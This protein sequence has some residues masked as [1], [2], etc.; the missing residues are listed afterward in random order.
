MAA[1]WK[2]RKLMILLVVLAVFSVTAVGFSHPVGVH[3]RAMSVLLRFADPDAKG[4]G[5]R[6]AQHP[7]TSEVGTTQVGTESFRYRI[8]KPSDVNNPPGMVLLCGVHHLMIEEPRLVN[9][10][11]ALAGAGIE[12]MTPELKDLADY[13]VVPRV[14]DVI[15]ISTAILKKQLGAPKVGIL[16]LS[17]AG[18]LALLAATKPEYADN[19][20][21][22]VTVGSHD[23]LGRVSRF[24]ATNT[25]EKPD[26][27]SAP[28]QAHE[29]GAL[30]LAYAHME[31]FFS[32]HDVP[33]AREALRLWLWGSPDSMKKVD[34]LTPEG[35]AK[36]EL[37]L[38][39][40]DQMRGQLLESIQKHT[41]EM[42]VVSPHG[43]I[44]H[45]SVPVLLLHA[46]G[47]TVIPP[48]ETLWL[49]K[50]VPA[51]ELRAMLISPALIH[52]SM[53]QSVPFSQ[54]WDLVD[55]MAKVLDSADKLADERREMA[56]NR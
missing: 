34:Q 42:R 44:Q 11:R 3:L 13:H 31:D 21:F 27:S 45:L 36:L 12:V 5:A 16:G 49:A 23:D 10:S 18:G 22:I 40:R 46:T 1:F 2:R 29:Y 26:G 53:E 47:D 7:F 14:I 28:L 39:H 20:G 52:V 38:H 6:F 15:G 41:E 25:V 19:I 8:Y 35:R 55:F 4:F 30:I 37:L 51:N 9:F 32:E 33:I 50:D 43:Q 48:A 17:F 56:A 24:F 54:K